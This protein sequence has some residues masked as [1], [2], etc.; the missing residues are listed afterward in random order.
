MA[1]ATTQI[2]ITAKDSTAAAFASVNSGL[3]GL[4]GAAVKAGAA[5]TAVGA[6]AA[7]GS[8]AAFTK[9]TIDAQDEL[10]K[11]SQK[12]GIA[13]ESLAGLQF[14]AEQSGVE[15]DKVA[16]ATRAF[17]LLVEEA[18]DSS[19][20]AAKK[21]QD[22]GLSYKV[23]K[24]LDPEKRVLALSDALQKFSKEDRPVALISAL[25]QK[26][27]DLIPLLSGGSGELGKLIEQGK[28]F[29]PVTEQSAKQAERFNDQINVLNKSVSALGR[30]FIQGMIPG[31]TRVADRM[32]EVT[33][34]S[35]LLAG[36][37][38]GVKQLFVESFGNPKILGDVGQ[39]RR[40]IFKTQDA[41]KNLEV[42]K[43]SVFFDR[44]ALAHEQEKLVQLEIDLKKAIGAS[45][46]IIAAQDVA[47]ASAKKFAISID[48]SNAPIAK[49]SSSIDSLTKKINDQGRVESEYIK[50]LK[51]ERQAQDELLRPYQQA[52]SSAQERLQS[53]RQETQAVDLA[54]KEQISLSEAIE[55]TTIARLQEKRAITTNGNAIAEIDKE[56]AARKQIIDVIKQT[57]AKTKGTVGVTR[58]ATDDVSQLWM[59]AGRNIQSTLANSIFNFFDDGLSG[60]VKNVGIA[61][62]RIASEFAALKLAQSIG[63]A[64]IF[65]GASGVANAAGAVSSGGSILGSAANLG[66]NALSLARGGFGLSGLF[67]GG[68]AGVF[69]NLGGAG[70]AFIGGPG[71][72]LGGSGLGGAASFGSV[73]GAALGGIAAGF[74][75]GSL[76]AGD[77]KLGP[78][79][80]QSSAAIGTAIGFAAGG[81][82]GAVIGGLIGGLTNALFGRGPYKFRQ[83]SLQGDFSSSGFD[84]DF[85]NVFRAKGG[86]LRSNGHRSITEDLTNQQQR[87]F[88]DTVTGL[89][90]SSRKFA[91]NLG[92]STSLV[93]TFT[94]EIQ[95]KSEKGKKITEEAITEMFAGFADSLADN[96]IPGIEKFSKG[97]ER[98]FET[99]E[100]LNSEFSSLTAGAQNL[101]ASVEYA[102]KLV[103]DMSITARTDLVEAA[104]GIEALSS[105]TQFFFQNFLTQSEQ[106]SVKSSALNDALVKLGVSADLTVDQYRKLIQ[107]TSTANDLR[108][109]LLDL[110]PAFLELRSSV[111]VAAEVVNEI[112]EDFT[113]F[114][115]DIFSAEQQSNSQR[116]ASAIDDITSS[117]KDLEGIAQELSGTVNEI[118]PLSVSEARGI[119]SGGNPNDPRLSQALAALSG[120]SSAG[121]GSSLE[122]NRSKS[123]N[124][125]A[126]S[127]L[128]SVIG[129][130]ISGKNA[131]IANLKV[132]EETQRK[133][134]ESILLERIGRVP[135]F[136]V[137]G[138]VPKTG[139]ALVHKNERVINPQQNEAIVDLLKMVVD[140]VKSGSDSNDKLYK[141]LR[142]MTNNGT[143]LNT[144][145]A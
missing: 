2:V 4:S 126:I 122:F 114:Y 58:S 27:A 54:Q 11:L 26:M 131:D 101:G 144:V 109:G 108:L 65:G 41:I 84:G 104:G 98:L 140:A 64:S 76:I 61:V 16:K 37:L 136:D 29:N 82:I 7:I 107:S 3:S 115:A 23:L 59:Q 14:A 121:F 49:R 28:K 85:T 117:I 86:L 31:L 8:F 110:G 68:S 143:A 88:D 138:V 87:L 33:Q 132:G 93:D 1:T 106:F 38:A 137:G 17:S 69:S 42:K 72:A 129:S 124:I 44:N 21:L 66:T 75:G 119:V 50:L 45:Q 9:Q 74:A 111:A 57:D 12:T 125:S 141:L 73:G 92:L 70:T 32:V 83:Q 67:S 105:K 100:R 134:L 55:R 53:L 113:N 52:A 47:S 22:L 40:E 103:S 6:T 123:Q 112:K 102:R 63:L 77:K 80:G 48:E 56:I 79:S 20:G 24:D 46:G 135:S 99:F 116:V 30:E 13:V 35:G 25:G 95:I 120:Q 139:L 71:T 18:A 19:S 90:D 81:P 127:S 34:Q 94:K 36:A 89:Y 96:V 10:F 43:D 39:I 5:L 78:L 60:M 62:G 91:E 133:I 118:A 128:Q 15:L 142:S 130:S 145:A 97:S 51:A